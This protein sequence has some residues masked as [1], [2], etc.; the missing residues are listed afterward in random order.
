MSHCAR[1]FFF[2]FFFNVILWQLKGPE[3][4]CRAP[5]RKPARSDGPS[6]SSSSSSSPRPP[7][8]LREQRSQRKI[9]ISAHGGPAANQSRSCCFP[10]VPSQR[11]QEACG[12]LRRRLPTAECVVLFRGQSV[13]QSCRELGA[14]QPCW[15]NWIVHSK[16]ANLS[17]TPSHLS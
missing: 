13:G 7:Q 17:L 11:Y 16:F 12:P 1:L 15:E 6:L 14:A 4:P 8:Q 9:C 10:K 2:F 5:W 3:G